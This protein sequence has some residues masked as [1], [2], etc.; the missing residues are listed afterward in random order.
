MTPQT[1]GATQKFLRRLKNILKC[2]LN[3]KAIKT[4]S[5]H[6]FT[7]SAKTNC[8]FSKEKKITQ[9]ETYKI[10]ATPKR[11]DTQGERETL[12][13]KETESLGHL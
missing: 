6:T 4:D 10:L 11:K 3:S 13:I 8:P 1:G 2:L 5:S 7:K 12:R 9:L